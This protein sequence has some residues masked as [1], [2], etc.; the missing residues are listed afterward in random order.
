MFCC[1]HGGRLRGEWMLAKQNVKQKKSKIMMQSQFNF[2]KV[3]S[4]TYESLE[5][6]SDYFDQCERQFPFGDFDDKIRVLVLASPTKFQSLAEEAVEGYCD[7]WGGDKHMEFREYYGGDADIYDVAQGE[8]VFRTPYKQKA[9]RL[10]DGGDEP[11]YEI[12]RGRI[13]GAILGNEGVDELERK[14]KKGQGS[15]SVRCYVAEFQGVVKTLHQ[16]LGS[17]D[18]R[19]YAKDFLKG[20]NPGVK[21]SIQ[22]PERKEADLA[23]VYEAAKAAAARTSLL[24]DEEPW[25]SAPKGRNQGQD[26][27]QVHPARKQLLFSP[28]VEEIS[29]PLFGEAE[30]LTTNSSD[31]IVGAFVYGL[32]A[33]T[34]SG[35][36]LGMVADAGKISLDE[37]QTLL[38]TKADVKVLHSALRGALRNVSSSAQ[39]EKVLQACFP[40]Q[41]RRDRV[42]NRSP[43]LS[44]P[45]TLGVRGTEALNAVQGELLNFKNDI[46]EK[47][48]DA[49]KT[50]MN[51]QTNFL[52]RLNAAEQM[53]RG[54]R[55]SRRDGERGG[56]EPRES[57][58]KKF[59]DNILEKLNSVQQSNDTNKR[60]WEAAFEDRNKRAKDED[61]RGSSRGEDNRG[62]RDVKQDAIK[63]YKCG[64]EGHRKAECPEESRGRTSDACRFCRKPGHTVEECETRKNHVCNECGNKGHSPMWCKPR[65]C[66]QCN[67]KHS[68]LNGCRL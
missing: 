43:P 10:L 23:I 51:A 26:K 13:L 35:A 34:Q 48:R 47:L 4:Y 32:N 58:F 11:S 52:E 38:S 68:L 20:L 42:D 59:Q 36:Y 39:L 53:G 19:R 31:P 9:T 5:G 55:G 65:D 22:I 3:K 63:C 41:F 6:L 64:K 33:V 8:R 28:T 29:H 25:S 21:Q 15:N 14:L 60:K 27:F 57:D 37:T 45:K 7:E 50:Q 24:G 30:H 2:S 40:R 54:S 66:K 61:R 67:K 18:Q 49:Q 56:Y 62:G 12:A 1:W 44:A 16:L 46:F 17:I